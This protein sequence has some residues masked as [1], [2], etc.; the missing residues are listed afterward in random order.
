MPKLPVISGKEFV[1][2]LEN[3]GFSV[4]RTKGS[5]VR[6]SSN[7]GRYTTIPVHENRDLPKGLIRKIIREDLELELSDFI[8]LWENFKC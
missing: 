5:H 7:D 1:K 3:I 6:L 4:I 2:F 8:R